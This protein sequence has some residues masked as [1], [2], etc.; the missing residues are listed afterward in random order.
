MNREL[1]NQG[2]ELAEKMA[3]KVSADEARTI[4]GL[5]WGAPVIMAAMDPLSAERMPESIRN[6]SLG[7]DV[8]MTAEQYQKAMWM[9]QELGR[10]GHIIMNYDVDAL[11]SVA[12]Q[13][14]RDAGII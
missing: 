9:F 8:E 5:A 10:S 14:M 3:G 6:L 7:L 13:A 2:K 1:R 4:S 12:Q 11:R